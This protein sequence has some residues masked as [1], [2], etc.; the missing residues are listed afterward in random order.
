LN[1]LYEAH[2]TLTEAR[3]RAQEHGASLHLLPISVN[4]AEVNSKLGREK[5][6]ENRRAEGRKIAE[7]MAESLR[8]VGLAES[9]LEQPRI[10]DLTQA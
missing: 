5:E 9:F 8:E 4:L 2:Q 10:K 1:R 3:S 7:Q 6:A